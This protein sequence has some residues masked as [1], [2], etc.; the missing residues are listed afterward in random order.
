MNPLLINFTI[1]IT[2]Q[3][4][5]VKL[6]HLSAIALDYI[7]YGLKGYFLPSILEDSLCALF[8]S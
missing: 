6:C 5:L 4:N 7:V 2:D 3:H 1:C 8:Y